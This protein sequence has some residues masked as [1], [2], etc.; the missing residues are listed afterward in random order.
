M[1]VFSDSQFYFILR[2]FRTRHIC[3]NSSFRF[4]FCLGSFKRP[5]QFI[6]LNFFFIVVRDLVNFEWIYFPQRTYRSYI[7]ESQ[8]AFR[9]KMETWQIQLIKPNFTIAFSVHVN[10]P[11]H[12]ESLKISDMFITSSIR[13]DFCFY[14]FF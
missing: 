12:V 8:C 13:V 2:H 4:N 14:V 11:R 7:L 6:F 3:G 9:E 10:K 1:W 5:R